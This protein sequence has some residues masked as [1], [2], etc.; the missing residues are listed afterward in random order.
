MASEKG[1]EAVDIHRGDAGSVQRDM[2]FAGLT[3][4]LDY[5]RQMVAALSANQRSL[6]ADDSQAV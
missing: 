5:L 4:P 6:D 3:E 2:G 1:H